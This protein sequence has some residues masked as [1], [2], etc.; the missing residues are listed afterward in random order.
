MYVCMYTNI[1]VFL[2]F[3]YMYVCM[4]VCMFVV[5]FFFFLGVLLGTSHIHTKEEN[6]GYKFLKKLMNTFQLED[7]KEDQRK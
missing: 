2:L 3:K 1:F 4:Y 6:S 7:E 5:K